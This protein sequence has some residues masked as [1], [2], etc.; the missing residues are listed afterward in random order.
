L[1]KSQDDHQ[2]PTTSQQNR[3]TAAQNQPKD[4]P[5]FLQLCV[6]TGGIYVTLE[7][8]DVKCSTS[9]AEVFRMMKEAYYERRGFRSRFAFLIK[10]VWVE[11][12]QFTLWSK[13]SG[14]VSICGRPQSIP[15]ADA[16]EWEYSPRPLDSLPPMPPEVFIHYLEHGEGELNPLRNIWAPRLPKRLEEKTVAGDVG[17]CGWGV[18]IVEGPNRAALFWIMLLTILAGVITTVAW[19]LVRDDAQGG[20][21][22]GTLI[23]A[24]PSVVL[25]VFLFRLGHA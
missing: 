1:A 10:P 6:N 11:F 16:K 8:L 2:E 7:E 15:P 18:H 12:V 17:A 13:R 24:L 20:S 4:L 14:F 19:S 22:L 9:D 25:A 23:V 5:K 21:G 3:S